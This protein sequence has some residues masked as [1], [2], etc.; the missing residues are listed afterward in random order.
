LKCPRA[1][2]FTSFSLNW[3]K[4]AFFSSLISGQGTSSPPLHFPNSLFNLVNIFHF[5]F[6]LFLLPSIFSSLQSLFLLTL[7][8]EKYFFLFSFLYF[9]LHNLF[10]PS[11]RSHFVITSSFY[12]LFT[13]LFRFQLLFLFGPSLQSYIILPSPVSSSLLFN[14]FR[15]AFSRLFLLSFLFIS[16]Y[17]FIIFL[18]PSL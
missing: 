16:T 5:Y 14:L 7:F 4:F 9:L 17:I 6:L 12:V 1:V 10:V 8:Y 13:L 2:A 18:F 11:F 15:P 3:T